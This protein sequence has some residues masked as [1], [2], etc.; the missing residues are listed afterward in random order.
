MDQ[1]FTTCFTVKVAASNNPGKTET[2][3]AV[4]LSDEVK[5]WI[6][7]TFPK[8]SFRADRTLSGVYWVLS[9][10]VYFLLTLKWS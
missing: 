5:D 10:E 9:E 6:V 7:N 3:Y 1:K 8:T 2:M 4:E